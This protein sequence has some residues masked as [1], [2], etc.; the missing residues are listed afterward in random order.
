MEKRKEFRGNRRGKVIKGWK[1]GKEGGGGPPTTHH[2][3]AAVR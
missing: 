2:H 1:G 3:M